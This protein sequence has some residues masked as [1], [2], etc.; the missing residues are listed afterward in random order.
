MVT[1][2]PCSVI[3]SVSLVQLYIYSYFHERDVSVVQYCTMF[4][5]ASLQLLLTLVTIA[6]SRTTDQPS[7]KDGDQADAV[8]L[9]ACARHF[10]PGFPGRDGRDGSKGDVGMPGSK[11]DK[12]KAGPPGVIDSSVL[13]KFAAALAKV[14]RLE[15]KL[16]SV[17][18]I[19]DFGT[20][21]DGSLTLKRGETHTVGCAYVS[22]TSPLTPGSTAFTVNSCSLFRRGDEIVIH[23]TQHPTLAGMLEYAVVQSCLHTRMTVSKPLSRPFESG[24]YNGIS[25]KVA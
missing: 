25:P 20:G 2:F 17:S 15:E 16:R 24:T 7:S 23:Q 22:Q 19:P 11:G 1:S 13:A 4:R 18:H 8:D 6:V 10:F 21:K 3:I 5:S 12:S 9:A 14:D